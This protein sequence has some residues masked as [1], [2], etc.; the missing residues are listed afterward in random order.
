MS[1]E[2]RRPD[3]TR[4]TTGCALRTGVKQC[5]GGTHSAAVPGNQPSSF[6]TGRSISRRIRAPRY[7]LARE[8]R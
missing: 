2:I 1:G 7:I 5:R 4:S 3:F 6:S 8:K